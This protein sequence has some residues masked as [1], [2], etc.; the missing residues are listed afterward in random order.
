[1]SN[2]KLIRPTLAEVKGKER[3]VPQPRERAN[4][5][6]HRGQGE[7]G[8]RAQAP[9]SSPH[10]NAVAGAETNAAADGNKCRTLLLQEAD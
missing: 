5:G 6:S 3:E 10:H 7:G 9:T 8:T 1:M 2:R 4:G